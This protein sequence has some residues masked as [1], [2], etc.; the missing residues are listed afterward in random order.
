VQRD[1]FDKLLADQAALA[2]V[3]I[4]YQHEITA[5]KLHQDKSSVSCRV[6]GGEEVEFSARFVLDASGFGRVLPR[7]LQLEEPSDFPV[8]SSLFTH[9]KDCLHKTDYDRNKILITV[10]PRFQDVWYWLIPFND[11]RCS[12]GVV[13]K[14]EFL[15]QYSGEP[16]SVLR[17]IVEEDPELVRLLKGSQWDTPARQITGYSAKARPLATGQ[18]ALLGN[19]AE[20]IDPVFSSGVTIALR[21]ASLAAGLVDR[22]LGGEHIDWENEYSKVLGK[23]VETFRAFVTAWYDGRFQDVIFSQGQ[24]PEIRRMMC[25]ILAGYAWDE[26]NPYVKNP[27][28]RLN[29][30]A[31]YCRAQT[32]DA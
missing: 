2:G 11:G 1:Q 22:Q 29:T 31:Q 3:D 10:H 23:G 32:T 5:V 9:L 24:S 4:R 17:T 18:Y 25:S 8:R 27:E 6:F 19:A 28:R 21:S 30:L 16:Q 20:F 13:A 15:Q 12:I 26:A 14:P 7:L